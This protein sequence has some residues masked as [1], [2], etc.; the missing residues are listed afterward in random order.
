MFMV[1]LSPLRHGNSH[2]VVTAISHLDSLLIYVP[3]RS[4][5]QQLCFLHFVTLWPLRC[6]DL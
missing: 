3:V 2:H 5:K 1:S 4:E 6:F